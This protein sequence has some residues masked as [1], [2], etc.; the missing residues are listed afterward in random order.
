MATMPEKLRDE[1]GNEWLM[2]EMDVECDGYG[3]MGATGRIV[4]AGAIAFGKPAPKPPEP[5]PNETIFKGSPWMTGQLPLATDS[6]F[7]PYVDREPWWYYPA[8]AAVLVFVVALPIFW[9]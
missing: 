1:F 2:T 6:M 3:V 9:R 7:I 4:S 8:V 5:P